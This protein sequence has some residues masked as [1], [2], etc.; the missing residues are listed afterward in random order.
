MSATEGI[1]SP[2]IFRLWTA[3]FTIAATQQRRTYTYTHVSIDPLCPNLYIG[4]AG[5]PGTG[6]NLGI[7]I[8]RRL[9]SRVR[10]LNISS[11]N[12]TK[13]SF[14]TEMQNSNR[15]FM[16]GA[17]APM[18]LS[19]LAAPI[20]ELSNFLSRNDTEMM[21]V[22]THIFDNPDSYDEPR[23]SVAPRSVDK[24]NLS[25]IA[26]VTPD[27][28]TELF[29]EVAWGQGFASRWIFIYSEKVRF[30]NTNYFTKRPQ[31]DLANLV[32]PLVR[33]FD[34][35]GE[36]TWSKEAQQAHEAWLDAD[37]PGAPDHSRLRHYASRRDI[38]IPKLAMISSVAAGRN[39]FV[40]IEDYERAHTW[41]ADAEAVMPDVFRAMI[42]KS[43][44]QLVADLH[45]EL[46]MKHWSRH[47]HT[48][49][50]SIP[51]EVLWEFLSTRTTSFNIP[52]VIEN[53]ER[54][55]VIRRDP[56]FPTTPAPRWIP[57]P[58]NEKANT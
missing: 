25:I 42:A 14:V 35:G 57:R 36:F 11:D 19:S 29:P 20:V 31:T 23:V 43:D 21:S 9:L 24:P 37:M 13:A 32:P 45:Y 1:R 50:Q 56:K 40:D 10:G 7:N 28:L 8:S 51:N 52:K 38:H 15:V 16:N 53:A 18:I 49:R 3:I 58:L 55:G 44:S 6:K 33:F 26:G 30:S 46:W 17:E 2:D 5:P 47:V 22:L 27:Y 4:L 41:L 12:F 54:S 34:Y 39:L 48:Q